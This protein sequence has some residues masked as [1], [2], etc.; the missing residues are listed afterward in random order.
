MLNTIFLGS[1]E[2]VHPII[3][4][5]NQDPHINL[6][7]T[8]TQPDRPVGRKQ[9]LTPTPI[10]QYA[11]DH[12]IPTLTPIKITKE[13]L[14]KIQTITANQPIHLAVLA[15]YGLIIPQW[16][17][18]LPQ[19]GIIN[20]HPSLLPQYRGAMPT[21]G[22]ILRGESTT[23]MTFMQ[24]DSQLDHGPLIAQFTAS[25]NQTETTDQLTAKL[26][27]QSTHY[28]SQIIQ[29]YTSKE[30][31]TNTSYQFF[32]PPQAQNHKQATYTPQLNKAEGYLPWN[33]IKNALNGKSN[34][35]TDFPTK[36]QPLLQDIYTTDQTAQ[37][38]HQTIH[39]LKSWPTAWT[40]IPATANSKNQELRIK[41]L[42]SQYD[43]ATTSLKLKQ[44]QLAGKTPQP[45][46]QFQSAYL[47]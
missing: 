8:I 33:L 17:L 36:L 12:S 43:Q 21:F 11:L 41:L 38:V 23:G 6:I 24:M 28:L 1:P 44:V 32:N 13:L 2:Y 26:F 39:A 19:H 40:T 22:P 47:N 3:D 25:I 27:Q 45:W 16:L 20:L 29:A 14:P 31:H 34:P 42:D 10:K 15:A 46:H 4:T 5:L 18:D 35:L 30:A 9:I 7:L 37:H